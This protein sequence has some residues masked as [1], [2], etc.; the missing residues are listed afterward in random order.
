MSFDLA[1]IVAEIEATPLVSPIP[2]ELAIAITCDVFRLGGLR[3]PPTA[4]WTRVLG[5]VESEKA[6]V[7][8]R[9]EQLAMLAHFLTM[10]ALRAESVRAL[11]AAKPSDLGPLLERFFDEI[12]PLT[13]E[14]MRANAFRREEA[15]RR[16]A[17]VCGAEITGETGEA[18]RKRLEELDYRTALVEYEKA[19]KARKEEAERR[20]EALRKAQEAEAAARGWRE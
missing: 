6:K 4:F 15:I 1:R 16:W 12:W 19:E 8:A 14:M 7:G 17:M 2:R 10:P 9:A 5:A 11:T 18:S 3:P 20:A 13:A